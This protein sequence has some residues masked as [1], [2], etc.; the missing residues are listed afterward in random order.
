MRALRDQTC[1]P[2]QALVPYEHPPAQPI[3]A[4]ADQIE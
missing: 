4:H 1:I 2:E 3:G